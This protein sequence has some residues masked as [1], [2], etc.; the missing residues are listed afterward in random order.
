VRLDRFKD[1]R[2]VGDRDTQI[3]YDLD[4]E[5]IGLSELEDSARRNR[6]IVFSPDALSEARNRGYRPVPR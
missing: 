5:Q 2:F 3:V 4:D 1:Y 6:I